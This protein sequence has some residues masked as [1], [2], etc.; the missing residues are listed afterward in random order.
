MV[1]SYV[2]CKNIQMFTFKMITVNQDLYWN[3]RQNIP[4]S[5]ISLIQALFTLIFNDKSEH[6]LRLTFFQTTKNSKQVVKVKRKLILILQFK[7]RST[8]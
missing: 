8:S 7:A 3:S 5:K 6:K 1:M 2:T 4:L